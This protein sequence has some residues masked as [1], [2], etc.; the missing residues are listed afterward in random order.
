MNERKDFARIPLAAVGALS[1]NAAADFE[2]RLPSPS[3]G[4]PTLYRKSG[5]EMEL[6]DYH[7]MREHGVSHLYVRVEDLA[8]CEAIIEGKLTSLL[9]QSQL[10]PAEKAGVIHDVGASVARNLMKESDAPPDLVRVGNVL[11]NVIGCV[12][13]DPLVASQLLHMADHERSVASHMFIVSTL[14]VL[15]GAE[16]YGSDPELLRN[17]GFAGML[18][19][20]GKLG[21]GSAI[22]NK[23]EPLSPEEVHMI[24]QHPIESVRLIGD[25]PQATPIVRQMILQH[26]E[27]VDGK[28]YPIGVCGANLPPPSRILAIVDSFHAMIGRRPYRAPLT[29]VEANR[30]LNNMAGKQFDTD[31]LACWNELFKRCWSPSASSAAPPIPVPESMTTS[32]HEHRLAPPSRKSLHQRVTRTVCKGNIAV[33]CVY[34]GRLRDASAAPKEFVAPVHDI[35]RRGLCVYTAHPLYRGEIL[36]V[37]FGTLEQKWVRAAVAW[38]RQCDDNTFRTGLR[39]SERLPETEAHRTASVE[40]P[41][42]S[43]KHQVGGG[44]PNAESKPQQESSPGREPAEIKFEN[45]HET[46]TAIAALRKIPPE[47]ERTVILLST[48]DDVNIRRKT[49]DILARIGSRAARSAIVS[50]LMDA[51]ASVRE[52]AA[53]T[54]GVLKMQEAGFQLRKLLRDPVEPVVLRAA[55]ALGRLDDQSGLPN[56][57]AVLKARGENAKLAAVIVGEIVGHRFSGN[58]EGIQAALRYLEA[59][60]DRTNQAER[61]GIKDEFLKRMIPT[62]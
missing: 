20:L 51:D 13:H 3:G 9:Q 40:S 48:F 43:I 7:R 49:V 11:D 50:L 6:P 31:L 15:M 47:E 1:G 18:H 32:K 28:G 59:Q 23:S 8:K 57:I 37:Q 30:V 35:S 5:G 33:R 55:G 29:A 27:R 16:V 58:A 17:F 10:S 4:A 44:T 21:I 12:L 34:A 54:A 26:H 53:A 25:A 42:E 2:V 39:F 19:D 41:R 62:R 45:A 14:A 22:L 36:H 46:L 61:K 52:R 24:E 60:G 38:C 56:T